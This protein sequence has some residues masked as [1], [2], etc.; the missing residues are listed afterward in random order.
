MKQSLS[1][2]FQRFSANTD[3]FNFFTRSLPPKSS[4]NLS[5]IFSLICKC[6]SINFQGRASIYQVYKDDAWGL[7][8]EIDQSNNLF[9]QIAKIQ[10]KEWKKEKIQDFLNWKNPKKPLQNKREKKSR[11]KTVS[12]PTRWYLYC[13]LDFSH[14]LSHY[15]DRVKQLTS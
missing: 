3:N 8:R 6:E 5:F 1:R 9:S 15:Q 14:H 13:H 11:F 4:V 2:P 7:L 12:R 10:P